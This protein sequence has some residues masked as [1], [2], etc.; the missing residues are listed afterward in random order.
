MFSKL[1]TEA[2]SLREL[3]LKAFTIGMTTKTPL[4]KNEILRGVAAVQKR[5]PDLS[6][7][8][9]N[10][11][12]EMVRIGNVE[13][14]YEKAVLL[15]I[16]NSRIFEF[17]WGC[18]T[19]FGK[20]DDV[21]AVFDTLQDG[22]ALFPL[23][24][25]L[26]DCQIHFISTWAGHHYAAIWDAFFTNSPLFRLFENR[27]VVQDDLYLRAML[28]DERVAAITVS[29]NVSDA[30]V[31]RNRFENDCLKV[32]VGIA[33]TRTLGVE[34]RLSTVFDEHVKFCANYMAD[35]VL[36]SVIKPL[37]EHIQPEKEVPRE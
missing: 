22:F 13:S 37:N 33:Y 16:S 14:E 10:Q 1:V 17:S 27:K 15:K 19:S 32:T 9:F 6:Q 4:E 36:T 8:D 26:I 25:L 2:A 28:A 20:P 7:I 29:S 18:E 5:F 3:R 23:N 31:K 24:V 34:D 35:T 12:D 30:E 11:K 21:L